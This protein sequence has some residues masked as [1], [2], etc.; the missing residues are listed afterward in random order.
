MTAAMVTTMMTFMLAQ[1]G[2][3]YSEDLS[4]RLGPNAFDC[5]G[6][7]YAALHKVGVAIPQGDSTAN[8]EAN[9]LGSNG[10]TVV[11]SESDVKPG[12][13]VFFHGAAPGPSNYGPI[14]HVGMAI[15]SGHM[16][17]AYDTASGILITPIS[18][19]QFTVG[20]RLSGDTIAPGGSPAP[21]QGGLGGI[22]SFPSE[23]TTFFTDANGFINKL[24]WLANPASWVRIVMFLVGTALLLFAVH[25]LVSAGKGEPL[26][27]MPSVIPVP[28]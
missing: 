5:S 26:V 19:D 21:S 8:T 25:A 1:R 4:R 7:V 13:L 14:G 12:D 18:Q 10:A 3:P 6:L 16:I 11:K 23:I 28:V 9:W 15:D 20:M 24:M 2:K 27:S 17:S 22:L